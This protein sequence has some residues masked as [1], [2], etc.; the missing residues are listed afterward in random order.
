MDML[1]SV[2]PPGELVQYILH[3]LDRIENAPH[4]SIPMMQRVRRAD[5]GVREL[6]G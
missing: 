2:A 6:V 5:H 3:L 4:P 1:E